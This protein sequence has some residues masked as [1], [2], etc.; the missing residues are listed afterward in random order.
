LIEIVNEFFE[1]AFR[2]SFGKEPTGERPTALKK[3]S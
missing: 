1:K 3:K 2:E